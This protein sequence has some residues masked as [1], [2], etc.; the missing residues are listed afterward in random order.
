MIL[1]HDNIL[2]IEKMTRARWDV[3]K[4]VRRHLMFL[5]KT[6]KLMCVPVL[7]HRSR[8][9]GWPGTLEEAPDTEHGLFSLHFHVNVSGYEWLNRIS[10]IITFSEFIWISRKCPWLSCVWWDGVSSWERG[11]QVVSGHISFHWRHNVWLHDVSG[12]GHNTATWPHSTLPLL[13]QINRCM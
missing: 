8:G 2:I 9:V 5:L 11:W 6:M 1:W 3:C 7:P 12:A 10:I 13:R 4:Y